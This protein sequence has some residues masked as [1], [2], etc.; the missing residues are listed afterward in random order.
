MNQ[1]LFQRQFALSYE[2][3]A[4]I[5]RVL[6]DRASALQLSP[7]L[8]Q[9][10]KLVCSEYCANLLDHQKMP[11]TRCSI[12]YGKFAG[13]YRLAITD[14]GSPWPAQT[15]CLSDAVLPDYPSESGMG[16]A[17]IKATFPDF[18]YQIL[19]DHN[20]IE[21][22][23]P[24]QSARKHLVIVDDSRSQLAMLTSYLE[25]N[26]QL[27]IFSQADDALKWL[28]TNHCDLVLTDLW[29]PNLNGLEFRRQVGH[30]RHHR[31]LPFV[32]LSGDTAS[33]TMSAVTQSGID[34]FLAKPINKQHLL[35]VLDRVLKRHHH[36]L[37][38]FEDNLLQRLEH[39]TP[40]GATGDQTTTSITVGKFNIQLS[41]EP[42][43]SGDFF[44]HQTMADG[45]EMMILGDL[46]GHGIAAKANGGTCYGLIQ[47]LLLNP[48]QTP[49][50]LCE[51]LNLY[52]YQ[53]QS[54]SLVCLLVIH[55]GT[56][57]R[58]TL[59]NA[60]MPKPILCDASCHHLN[61][62]VGLLGLFDTLQWEA[63]QLTM[64]PGTSLHGYS[65]G[66]LESVLPE[67]ERKKMARMPID[68]RHHY[69]WQRNPDSHDD[70]RTL[71]SVSYRS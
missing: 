6:D 63:C 57:N 68:E 37:D 70:D 12:C 46:M 4:H 45:S 49:A 16:L 15:Q 39:T 11:A 2:N 17:I 42:K 69:L 9:S 10:I 50:Q 28:Q 24:L 54:N 67:Q 51:R 65:D 64:Q 3:L 47:G 14:N 33:D 62:T 20:K 66:L 19:P 61:E 48:A 7:D 1:V 55:L 71:V 32:F 43:I 29:M 30:L 5:R 22:S 36:L 18:S 58:V 27:S 44:I 35:Q 41:R 59:Y 25:Q 38:A 60:G 34:D 56:E 8:I 13:Q 21:F 31:L 23:L 52:L 53:A 26:Y 40:Q